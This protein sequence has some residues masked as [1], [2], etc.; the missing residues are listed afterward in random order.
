MTTL[1]RTSDCNTAVTLLKNNCFPTYAAARDDLRECWYN[2][3]FCVRQKVLICCEI[4]FF[5]AVYFVIFLP[6]LLLLSL[7]SLYFLFLFS[8]GLD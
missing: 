8:F 2:A 6:C 7:C 1:R 3:M 4:L 5:R